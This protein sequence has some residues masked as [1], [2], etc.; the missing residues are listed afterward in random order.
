MFF[1]PG[2]LRLLTA[3]ILRDAAAFAPELIL[4]ASIVLLL[5]LRMFKV[6][7]RLHLGWVA[8]GCT[9]VALLVAFGQWRDGGWFGLN[10]PAHYQGRLEIFSG[11]L[12]FDYFTVFLRLFLLS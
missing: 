12:V 8:L 5:L 3:E 4:S 11:L 10:T 2:H 9:A 1:S 7:D 6:F